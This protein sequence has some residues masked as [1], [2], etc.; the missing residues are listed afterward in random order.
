MMNI[1]CTICGRQIESKNEDVCVTVNWVANDLVKKNNVKLNK[2]LP[3]VVKI[4]KNCWNNTFK[5]KPQGSDYYW[6]F[7]KT[8]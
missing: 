7:D 2:N 8:I 6:F 4:C 5:D 1:Q 3:R